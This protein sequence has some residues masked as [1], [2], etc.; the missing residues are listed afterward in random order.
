VRAATHDQL[1]ACVFARQGAPRL[2][3]VKVVLVVAQHRAHDRHA[4]RGKCLD[5][6]RAPAS[7]A[8][9][10][11]E[12]ALQRLDAHVPLRRLRALG[13]ALEQRLDVRVVVLVHL[14]YMRVVTGVKRGQVGPGRCSRVAVC[15]H[16]ALAA[17]ACP[18]DASDLMAG[19]QS[20][21][22]LLGFE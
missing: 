15:A 3:Q 4:H 14:V 16:T 20:Q 21:T 17:L 13:D 18:D 7:A 11:A 9:A 19:K 5:R 2:Q 12:R 6:A 10:A 8:A 22:W 1:A